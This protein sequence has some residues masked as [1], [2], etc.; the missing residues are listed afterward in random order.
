VEQGKPYLVLEY[1]HLKVGRGNA[2]IKVRVRDLKSGAVLEKSFISGA[3]VEEGKIERKR[4]QYLYSDEKNL[5]F[6]DPSSFEQFAIPKGVGGGAERFLKDGTEVFLQVFQ[7]EPI[8][9]ELPPKVDLKVVEA[10][11][12]DKGDT[13]QGGSKEATVETGYKLQVPMFVKVGEI[14]QVNTETGEYAGRA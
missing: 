1:Q 7:D 10:P 12:G 2:N 14:I 8:R 5:I 11:P 4:V 13:K 3:V 9:V 6:M